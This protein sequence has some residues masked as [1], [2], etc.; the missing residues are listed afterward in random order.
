MKKVKKRFSLIYFLTL[1]I[2]LVLAVSIVTILIKA[3]IYPDK[4]PD[5]LGYKPMIVMS[6]SMEKELY[7]GDLAI[8]KIVDVDSLKENDIIAFRNSDN[9]VTTHR[10][11]KIN[12]SNEKISFVT[13]GDNNNSRDENVVKSSSVEGVYLYKLKGMGNVLMFLQ[14]S[15]GL[16]VSL[17]IIISVGM[18]WI[19]ITYKNDSKLTEDE[20]NLLNEY[21]MKKSK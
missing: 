3:V 21:R 14:K 1:L 9:T 10:I 13:K 11:I 17:L 7:K 12:N 6:G 2:L 15:I 5:F 4:I 18:V 19:L 20:I 8:V 16:V